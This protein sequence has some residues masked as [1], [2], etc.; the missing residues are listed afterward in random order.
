MPLASLATLLT[1]LG[2]MAF[3]VGLGFMLGRAFKPDVKTL[4]NLIIYCVTPVVVFGAILQMNFN[5]SYLF[6]PVLIW[7]TG[8][9]VSSTAY[10]LG[11]FSAR[12]SKDDNLLSL[13]GST[14]NSGYFGLPIIIALFPQEWVG[15]YL[16]ANIGITLC[17]STFGYYYL[18]RG[19]FTLRDSLKRVARLPIFYAVILATTLSA[20]GVM[21]PASLIP[22]WVNFKGTFVVVGMMLIGLAI[23]QQ[24]HFHL[25]LKFLFK[26]LALRHLGWGLSI[27]G[28]I[29]LDIQM[30]HF[31][32]PPIHAML[33]LYP[34][35]PM[36]ANIVALA[37]DLNAD[38]GKATLTV[39]VSHIVGMVLV[40]SAVA[41]GAFSFIQ[42]L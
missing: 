9:A 26:A 24:T 3:L 8:A 7:G 20:C 30:F 33:A 42:G 37:I 17:E 16:L 23:A 35:L 2:F 4:A 36:A 41:L 1:Q 25:D 31:F 12:L 21:L 22:A 19:H 32:A 18:A 6:L 39:L 40:L 15:V 14:A 5:P 28:F 10:F 29:F 38:V 34:L 13:I 11:K 27:Y